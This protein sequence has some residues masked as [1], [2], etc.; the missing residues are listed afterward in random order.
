MSDRYILAA[1]VKYEQNGAPKILRVTDDAQVVSNQPFQVTEDGFT[2]YITTDGVFNVVFG[3]I[4]ADGGWQPRIA[5]DIRWAESARHPYQEQG[6]ELSIGDLVLANDDRGLDFLIN[7]DV[8]GFT[9]ELRRGRPSDVWDDFERVF[10]ARNAEIRVEGIS[11]IVIRLENSLGDLFRPVFDE[12]FPSGTPNPQLEGRQKPFVLGRVNQAPV[13]DFDPSQLIY[14]TADNESKV[15]EVQEGGNPTFNWV[16]DDNN[17][18]KLKASPSLAITANFEGAGDTYETLIDDQP[19]LSDFTAIE[20]SSN[21]TVTEQSD[22]IVLSVTG[23]PS[24]S[25]CCVDNAGALSVPPPLSINLNVGILTNAGESRNTWAN[26][27]NL[28][29]PSSAASITFDETLITDEIAYSAGRILPDPVLDK[30]HAGANLGWGV[31]DMVGTNA[32]DYFV[33]ADFYKVTESTVA[34]NP[35]DIINQQSAFMFRFEPARKSLIHF[36]PQFWDYFTARDAVEQRIVVRFKFDGPD[37]TAFNLD[38]V[39][40]SNWIT[41]DPIAGIEYDIDFDYEEYV[42]AEVEYETTSG[43]PALLVGGH[44]PLANHEAP[45][46]EDALKLGGVSFNSSG[47]LTTMVKIAPENLSGSNQNTRLR[48]VATPFATGYGPTAGIGDIKITN[49]KIKRA[50]EITPSYKSIVPYA[51]TTAGISPSTSLDQDLIDAHADEFSD[52]DLGWLITGNESVDEVLFRLAGSLFGYVWYGL[53][54]KVRSKPLELPAMPTGDFFTIDE[55]R[56]DIGDIVT[57]DDLAPSLTRRVQ[58]L[59]NWQP[60][61]TDRQ[62]GILQSWFPE[63]SAAVEAEYRITR[64]WQATTAENAEFNR[65]WPEVSKR[66]GYRSAL[67]DAT[68]AQDV[69]NRGPAL[70]IQRPRFYEIRCFVRLGELELVEV[71]KTVKVELPFVGLSNTP[72]LVL[73]REGDSRTGFVNLTLWGIP[74]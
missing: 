18:L 63:D 59:R 64:E 40:F 65:K 29:V 54:G 17:R 72:L 43:S 4:F 6:G 31:I 23:S 39:R 13:L 21:A 36:V 22:G 62:A 38:S 61:S 11:R 66:E 2:P 19:T 28:F 8:V 69:A 26:L 60:I 44:S 34:S 1:E 57:Y 16:L 51:L 33:Y 49:V 73:G 24:E 15:S 50:V 5:S 35:E 48:I 74:A 46:Y 27:D 55:A 32:D 68:T 47:T 37:S 52:P 41:T 12:V 67:L 56:A 9:T 10:I 71:G 30:K 14:F 70:W 25:T 20:S 7:S 42:F 45:T 3:G 58:A 53:D